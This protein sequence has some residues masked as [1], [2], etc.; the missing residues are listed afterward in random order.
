MSRG[1]FIAPGDKEG[2]GQQSVSPACLPAAKLKLIAGN[3]QRELM[4]SPL[5]DTSWVSSHFWGL[6]HGPLGMAGKVLLHSS[7]GGLMLSP[8]LPGME[9]PG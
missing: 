6:L 9:R 3:K 5:S 8:Q 7:D 1:S 4:A 2:C